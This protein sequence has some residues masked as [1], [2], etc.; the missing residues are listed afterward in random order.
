[1]RTFPGAVAPSLLAT[2]IAVGAILSPRAPVSA[3]PAVSAVPLPD[4]AA[5]SDAA[6]QKSDLPS[7]VELQS[8]LDQSDQVAA[9]QALQ[10]ALNQVADGGTFFWKKNNRDLKGFIKPTG[11]FRNA[12][13]QICRHVIYGISLGRYRKQIEIVACREAGGRWRL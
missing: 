3:R 9:L 2:A 6:L 8:R 12:S 5:R 11:V 4:R 1:M 7:F 13:G 10:M